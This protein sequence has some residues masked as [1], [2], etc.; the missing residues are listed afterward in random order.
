M[1]GMRRR[2]GPLRVAQLLRPARGPRS[3]KG[4]AAGG[5][6]MCM[7]RRVAPDARAR[8]MVPVGP[9]AGGAASYS[10]VRLR[11]GPR[12]AHGP[13]WA[14][15]RRCPAEHAARCRSCGVAD[16]VVNQVGPS[17]TAH[18]SSEQV[19][20]HTPRRGRPSCCRNRAVPPPPATRAGGTGP[21]PSACCGRPA[22]FNPEAAG[23][24]GFL[25]SRAQARAR[26]WH[27]RALRTGPTRARI[28]IRS[29]LGAP[30]DSEGAPFESGSTARRGGSAP[31]LG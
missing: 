11:R 12:A 26:D 21:A 15:V 23:G 7:R 9:T 5:A 14:P 10:A 19:K 31:R 13:S 3:P 27:A 22:A 2:V 6:E 24:F 17:G 18:G 25:A 1:T 8:P 4:L 29:G 28:R 30:F 16:G 20:A